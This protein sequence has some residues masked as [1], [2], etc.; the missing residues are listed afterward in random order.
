M[1]VFV[2]ISAKPI[3]HFAVLQQWWPFDNWIRAF[4][5]RYNISIHDSFKIA[6]MKLENLTFNETGKIPNAKQTSWFWQK[7]VI[8]SIFE[9]LNWQS[10]WLVHVCVSFKIDIV[11]ISLKWRQMDIS[12]IT[13]D[14]IRRFS[15]MRAHRTLINPHKS[16]WGKGKKRIS[17][18][19]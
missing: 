7:Y 6:E 9:V 11:L 8:S 1:E 10:D 5:I 12:S 14:F 16:T 2:H 4:P 19:L 17:N 15:Y 3:G 13:C 18:Y